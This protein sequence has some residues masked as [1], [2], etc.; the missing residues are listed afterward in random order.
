LHCFALRQWAYKKETNE[1]D[2]LADSSDIVAEFNF[3]SFF[4]GLVYDTLGFP[5]ETMT[6]DLV[7][8]LGPYNELKKLTKGNPYLE[9][10]HL[11]EVR[12]YVAGGVFSKYSRN[13]APSV[14]VTKAE[15]QA[16]TNG[17]RAHYPYGKTNYT[18]MNPSSIL[19]Y[20]EFEYTS[21]GKPDWWDYIC[22][23]YD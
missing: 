11:I 22:S 13:N 16:L 1:S 21:G 15:H 5:S 20:F 17:F 7:G 10:H 4:V 9:V 19:S 6:S 18:D 14:I 8:T 12:F 2:Q 3:C 23:C